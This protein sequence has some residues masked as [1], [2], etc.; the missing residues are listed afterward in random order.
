[1][2]RLFTPVLY[3][4]GILFVVMAILLLIPLM[5]AWQT[6]DGAFDGF[7]QAGRWILLFG[8]TL[9]LFFKQP[10]FTLNTRQLYL[11]T[12][13]SWCALSFAGA[14][15]LYFV[16][17]SLSLSDAVFEAVS[18]ITTTGS[19]I[20]SDLDTLPKS[21]LIWRAVLQWIGGIGV[22]G[23]AVSIL[24]FLKIGGMRLFQTESSDWSEKSLPRFHNLARSLLAA[25]TGLTLV[26]SACYWFAGM[27][28]FDS[29]AHAMTTVSTGGYATS[30][31]SMGR[32][33]E[34]ILWI[35]TIFMLIGGMPF[36][37]FIRFMVRPSWSLL[38]DEQV[39][40]FIAIVVTASTSLTLYLIINNDFT[41]FTA[42][43][44]ATFNISSVITTTGYASTDYTL[45]GH[46]SVT[47]FFIVMFV[48]GCS[49]STSGGMKVFR[50]QISLS[51]LRAQLRQLIHPRALFVVR[52]NRKVIAE[53]VLD[54]AVAFSFI[55]FI[56]L[57]IISLILS[58]MGLDFVTSFTAAAT[59]LTNVGPGLGD[60]I[61][62]AGNFSTLPPS[63]KWVLS[64]AMILGR[65]ELLTI[66]VLFTKTFWKG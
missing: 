7:L 17:K 24:P 21:L 2:L 60:I 49:G 14:L 55:F 54:S 37:L 5:L 53:D 40:G 65:L 26:C 30:D 47:L 51:V 66:M 44:Q 43:T 6:H 59:A 3:V 13:F 48:G 29:I 15:P 31:S 64:V 33:D 39:R 1:M 41:F 57:S 34:N 9:I 32:F 50:F 23:M 19:T 38:N 62:P 27:T 18:G 56:T 35:A 58:A 22:I 61:G 63:A 46:F 36:T 42:L 16:I 12:A 20:L 10:T 4:V 25:Y 11:L 52:Y 45:W 28:P 8:L